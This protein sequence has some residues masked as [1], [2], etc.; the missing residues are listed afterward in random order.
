LSD[1]D[2]RDSL[3]RTAHLLRVDAFGHRD[4]TADRAIVDGLR[5]TTARIVAD[6]HNLASVAGQTALVTLYTQLA[7]TG[8][9]IDLDI[10][11]LE[12]LAP[13]PPLRGERLN[14][15]LIAY[16]DDLHEGGASS[17]TT[18][19]DL[20]F[21]LGDTPSLPGD[22]VVAGGGTRALVAPGGTEVPHWAGD[23][24]IGA[25]AAA[26][27]AA[28]EATRVAVA[29]I[30]DRL[31]YTVADDHT[32]GWTPGPGRMV[33]LD[34]TGYD[35]GPVDLGRVDLVSGGAITNAALYTLLRTRAAGDL[36]VLEPDRLDY[37]NLNRY[38][39]GRRS[40]V[41][42]LKAEHLAGYSTE[43]L[44]IAGLPVRLDQS[45]RAVTGPLSDRVL[46]GV[47][48]IPT[49]WEAQRQAPGWLC[50][51]ATSH[52]F[53]MVTVHPAGGPC[54][55]C[56]HPRDDD[57]PAEPIPTIAFVSLWSGLIQALELLRHAH[58][59]TQESAARI[60]IHPLGLHHPRGVARH[61]QHVQRH[62]TCPVGCLAAATAHA[63]N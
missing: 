34:L 18:H 35:M 52:A 11:D 46:V 32:G 62:Q 22:I 23:S 6:R 20:T 40:S 4:A 28:A 42:E 54:A 31:G 26:A 43:Q 60:T 16:S 27:A 1:G 9:Q 24:A 14:R 49:R 48:H 29:G 45:S 36:R 5:T 50:V 59:R 15:A 7:M 2:T 12:L 17:P 44:R 38:A 47:D 37:S 51:G 33:S 56:A 3:S 58:R 30:A 41:G 61:V 39:L 57:H 13:Q 8:L 25:I 55:G 19:P 63:A 10:P 53:A 21:V